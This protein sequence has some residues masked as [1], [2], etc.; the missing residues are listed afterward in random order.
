M[1]PI[2]L[3]QKKERTLEQYIKELAQRTLDDTDAKNLR[4]NCKIC[5]LKIFATLIL[6][7]F[8]LLPI[9][10]KTGFLV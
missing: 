9:W 7:F 3:V 1:L 5:I 10:E 2:D 8:L 6:N 4:T